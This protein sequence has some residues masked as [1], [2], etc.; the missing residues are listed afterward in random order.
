MSD[1]RL[2]IL[3]ELETAASVLSDLARC[4]A[5]LQGPQREQTIKVMLV[6][7]DRVDKLLGAAQRLGSGP[8]RRRRVSRW[9]LA[10]PTDKP[11]E[12]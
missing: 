12:E 5:R 2:N 6:Q 9:R 11:A 10:M 3:S 7:A 8:P 1:A 4:A